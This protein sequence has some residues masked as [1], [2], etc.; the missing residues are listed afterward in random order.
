MSAHSAQKGKGVARETS[1]LLGLYE[2]STASDNSSLSSDSQSTKDSSY[3][4]PIDD[5]VKKGYGAIHDAE[6]AQTPD[7]PDST[8]A[9]YSRTLIAQVVGALVI[10]Q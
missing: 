8:G 1:P 9:R 5:H 2:A 7:S 10:G 3:I 6:S 4:D